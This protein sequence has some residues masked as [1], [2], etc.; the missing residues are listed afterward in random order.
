[1]M[2]CVL[3]CF[4]IFLTTAIYAVI[5][6]SSEEKLKTMHSTAAPSEV[7]GDGVSKQESA[8]DSQKVFRLSH[9]R[10]ISKKAWACS[11]LCGAYIHLYR[12][13]TNTGTDLLQVR[14]GL[15]YQTA[16]NK[17]TI[18][19]LIT[20]VLSPILAVFY[21]N[22]GLMSLGTLVSTILSVVTYIY[23][24]LLPTEV[25]G[26]GIEIGLF[27]IS[28]FAT[29]FLSCSW[30]M[31]ILSIPRQASGL[32]IAITVTFQNILFFLLPLI[33]SSIYGPRTVNA[34]Q[35]F[36]YALAGLGGICLLVA[37]VL[38]AAD[39]TSGRILMMP[40]NDIKVK[41]AQEKQSRA[42]VDSVLRI[43]AK[44]ATKTE[45][46]TLGVATTNMWKSVV[47]SHAGSAL[48]INEGQFF[49][50]DDTDDLRPAKKPKKV[51]G[52]VGFS[53]AVGEL[54]GRNRL[55]EV[56]QARKRAMSGESKI[57]QNLGEELKD[58]AQ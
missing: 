24:S 38:F 48:Q 20:A 5:D 39:H 40:E 54:V 8:M 32:M 21:S 50:N 49:R 45:F 6:I 1:M 27:L 30:S 13:F 34:Y 28:L 31:L 17:L 37:I 25:S 4:I 53:P 29:M 44:S 19:P 42:F 12:Q 57:E 47:R 51:K 26:Y 33:F 10:Y 52:K 55:Q 14:F 7:T 18:L 43:Q 3:Y 41:K 16:K 23:F 36:F 58:K 9:L 11:L 22:F 15:D 35:N 46:G 2:F 56:E